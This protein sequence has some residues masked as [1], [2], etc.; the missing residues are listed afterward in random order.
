MTKKRKS[1]LC[2]LIA[3]ILLF[4]L[5]TG[6]AASTVETRFNNTVTVSS[7]ASISDSGLLTVTNR[8]QGIKG[9][10]AKGEIT[11]YIEKKVMG[12]FW[13]RVD[14]G[15][16]NN[17]WHDVIYDYMYV[18]DHKTQLSSHGTYRITVIYVI[19]GSGGD[20]DTIKRTMTKTY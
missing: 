14:I 19:S 13:F 2:S 1:I 20:P 7:A 17:E 8:F 12:L 11:T 16:P 18:G 6:A 3:V 5:S 4:C 9:T 15:A 10:T